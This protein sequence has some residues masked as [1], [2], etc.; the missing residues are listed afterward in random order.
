M[1]GSHKH[2]YTWIIRYEPDYFGKKGF[3]PLKR[4]SS[5]TI[6]LK[7]LANL[8]EQI[9]PFDRSSHSKAT[10]VVNLADMGYG[11]LIG[12]GRVERPLIVVAHKWSKSSEEKIVKAGGKIIKPEEI[13]Q[14]KLD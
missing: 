12:G 1:A 13:S 5:K 3:V 14:N 2:R 11:R 8:V 10:P 9:S 6:N 4:L 7:Q